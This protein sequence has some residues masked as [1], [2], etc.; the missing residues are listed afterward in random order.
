MPAQTNPRPLEKLLG[1]I[2]RYVVTTPEQR[3]IIALWIVHAHLVHRFEQTPYLAVSS[4]EKQCGKSLLLELTEL[5]VPRPW[6]T[7]T[8]SEATVYRH[9]DASMPTLLLDEFDAIFNPKSAER[10]EGLRAIINAGHRQGA[11]VPRCI[12]N[13]NAVVH[14]RVYCAKVLAGIGVL[15]D[16][17]ADR[18]VPIRLQRKKRSEKITRFR[19][20]EVA[21]LAEPIRDAIAAWASKHGD[22]IAEARPVMPEELSDRM[23][24]S[25]EPLLAIADALGY[26]DEARTALVEILSE[27]RVDSTER[28]QVK[29]LS[30]T[31]KLLADREAAA[32]STSQLLNSLYL[33]DGWAGYYGR[34][35]ADRDLSKMLGQYGIHP[36]SVWVPATETEEAQNV[37]GYKRDAFV[38][39]WDRYLTEEEVEDAPASA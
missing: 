1:I 18:S 23:R 35:L 8:P 6:L 9:V 19:R 20:R 28:M 31:R 10:Y 21:A 17:I 3:L 36:M 29:L 33:L 32:I 30:D 39:A 14:F 26:G 22:A 15:P 16:T 12:G 5:L 25:C 2:E 37:R 4:P 11:T 34:G 38:E 7:I 24:D 13:T 27:E